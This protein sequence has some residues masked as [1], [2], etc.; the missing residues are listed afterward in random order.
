[1]TM[2]GK[3]VKESVNAK[4]KNRRKCDMDTKKWG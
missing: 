1:M 4:K 2:E 3:V